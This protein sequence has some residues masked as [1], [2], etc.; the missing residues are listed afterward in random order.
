MFDVGFAELLIIALLALVVM[1]PERLPHA[2]RSVMK[3]V[4]Y[5]RQTATSLRDTVEQELKLDE[6]KNDL[7][8]DEIERQVESFRQQATK[9]SDDF[10]KAS[11][12]LVK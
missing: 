1:G 3:W 2:I 4:H 12:N 11:Q 8:T 9:T 7:K 5:L 6:I 10:E